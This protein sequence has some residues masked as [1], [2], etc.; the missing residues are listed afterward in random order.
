MRVLRSSAIAHNA[1]GTGNAAKTPMTSIIC[2]YS[3][4]KSKSPP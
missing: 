2:V 3:N 1:N 4:V